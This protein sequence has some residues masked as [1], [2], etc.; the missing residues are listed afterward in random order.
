MPELSSRG[1]GKHRSGRGCE[2]CAAGLETTPGIC[3]GTVDRSGVEVTDPVR[4]DAGR[5][6]ITILTD[7]SVEVTK[8][9]LRPVF[10]FRPDFTDDAFQ[11]TWVGLRL[12]RPVLVSLIQRSKLQKKRLNA[13]PRRNICRCQIRNEANLPGRSDVHG[14]GITQ[15]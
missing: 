10:R 4:G 8:V 1:R 5:C 12:E 15:K 7:Q 11:F 2:L 9:G 14:A 6:G 3:C 13:R